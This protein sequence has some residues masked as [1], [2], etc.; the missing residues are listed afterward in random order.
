MKKN[1]VI[2]LISAW[3]GLL[4]NMNFASCWILEEGLI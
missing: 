4:E 3:G 1:L 2:A